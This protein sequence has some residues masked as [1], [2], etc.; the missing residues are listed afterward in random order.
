MTLRIEKQ[1][2]PSFGRKMTSMDLRHER[3]TT[4]S[5]QKPP[6]LK[7]QSKG[8]T[9]GDQKRKTKV[10]SERPQCYKCKDSNTMLLCVLQEIKN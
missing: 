9:S 5:F 4:P 1:I 10:T 8:T 2:G 7:D 3:V 6:L